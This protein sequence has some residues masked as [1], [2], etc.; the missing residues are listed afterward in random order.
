MIY[1]ISGASRSGKSILA[2]KLQKK[3]N[4]SYL[5]LDSVMM[6][7][8]YGVK[9]I[10]I[11]DKLWPDEIAVKLWPFLEAFIENL[12]Y[13]EMDYIIE[14]EAMLPNLI[15][16]ILDKYPSTIKAVFIIYDNADL[17][18]KI[19]NCKVNNNGEK[20]WLVN[21]SDEVIKNHITNMISYSKK[22]KQLCDENNIEY[23]DTSINFVESIDNAL[24]SLN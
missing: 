10:G 3:K 21:E 5:P 18:Q 9:E 13:N 8:M 15:K 23:Y 14:G 4:I 22:I 7:F 6:A 20:D 12:L 1:L 17:D 24:S 16:P 2:R 11:H 19:I